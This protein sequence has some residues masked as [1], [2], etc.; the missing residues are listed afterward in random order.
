MLRDRVGA[1]ISAPLTL[2]ATRPE[3]LEVSRTT[4]PG[5]SLAAGAATWSLALNNR[6]PHGRWQIAAYIDPKGDP[7]GRVQFD[8]AD[9][10]PQRLKVALTAETRVAHANED[11]R[12][13]VER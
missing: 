5:A 4:V 2:V 1:A 3:G 8:V 13:K 12:I 11:I 6:A 9:F 7:V 10:V